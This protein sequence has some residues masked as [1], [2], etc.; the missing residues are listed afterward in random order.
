MLLASIAHFYR[1]LVLFAVCFSA[2][3]ALTGR[4]KGS[5]KKFAAVGF[6]CLGIALTTLGDIDYEPAG[7]HAAVGA[8]VAAVAKLTLMERM[9]TKEHYVHP[10]S[11]YGTCVCGG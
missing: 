4:Q 5:V 11:R 6:I 3:C 1:V 8:L 9:L 7:L 2:A 10:Y